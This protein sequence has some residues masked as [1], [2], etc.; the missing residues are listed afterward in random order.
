M[1]PRPAMLFVIAVLLAACSPDEGASGTASASLSATGGASQAAVSA[2]A[3]TP[4]GAS[5]EITIYGAASLKGVLEEVKSAY[6]SAQPGVTLT[7]S[8][9]SSTALPTLWSWRNGKPARSCIRA[10]MF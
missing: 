7:V 8:T 1:T 10:R 2:S 6:A 9:D 5:S 3:S 4:N